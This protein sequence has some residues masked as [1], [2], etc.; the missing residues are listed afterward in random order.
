MRLPRSRVLLTP[1]VHTVYV[2]AARSTSPTATSWW[3][4]QSSSRVRTGDPTAYAMTG[5]WQG[6]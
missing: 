5:C 1:F 3:T 2:N 4:I 6:C